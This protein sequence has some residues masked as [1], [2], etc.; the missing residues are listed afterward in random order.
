MN[1]SQ[2]FSRVWAAFDAG[3]IVIVCAWC[4]R[5]RIDDAWFPPPPAVGDAMDARLPLSHSICSR[6]AEAYLPPPVPVTT[7]WSEP[8]LRGTS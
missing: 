4:K 8:R 5:V 1:A 3:E 6:C 2:V 7:V